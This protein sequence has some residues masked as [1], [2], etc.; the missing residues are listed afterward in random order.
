MGVILLD[1]IFTNKETLVRDQKVESS[2]VCNILQD[3]VHIL[4]GGG[5]ANNG[6]S[7]L[8]VIRADFALSRGLF[9][10]FPWDMVLE[11]GLLVCFSGSGSIHP[12]K[13]ELKQTAG[14]L[15]G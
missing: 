5:K 9:G 13:K 7:I 3:G 8:D 4:R 12:D 6:I 2:R 14:C 10:K 11:R 15:D 1:H